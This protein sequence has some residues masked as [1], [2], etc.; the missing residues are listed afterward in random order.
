MAVGVPRGQSI[1][2]AADPS[3]A[4]GSN[5]GEVRIFTRSLGFTDQDTPTGFTNIVFRIIGGQVRHSVP[6]L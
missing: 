3:R 4:D 1:R 5:R 2:N 6:V